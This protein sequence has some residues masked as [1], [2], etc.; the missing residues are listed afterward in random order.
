MSFK[1]RVIKAISYI[2]AVI[3]FVFAIFLVVSVVA[4]PMYLLVWFGMDMMYVT[5]NKEATMLFCYV[6]AAVILVF[7]N[8]RK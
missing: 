7:N 3:I 4:L 8:W 6:S 1:D 5:F 2:L